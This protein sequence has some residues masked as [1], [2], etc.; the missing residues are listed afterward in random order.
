M[1]AKLKFTKKVF[2]M[3]HDRAIYFDDED[4]R[5]CCILHKGAVTSSVLGKIVADNPGFSFEKV[6]MV[7]I[8][9]KIFSID[10][11][12]LDS[13]VNL[14]RVEVRN[15]EDNSRKEFLRYAL[16]GFEE[17]FE[18]DKS[19]E[20]YKTIW[21]RIAKPFCLSEA[22]NDQID[23]NI[24]D[25]TDG[26]RYGNV[27]SENNKG[28]LKEYLSQI[29][30]FSSCYRPF[31]TDG[32]IH[33]KVLLYQ[34][35]VFLVDSSMDGK[36][37]PIPGKDA[38]IQ[39]PNCKTSNS[40]SLSEIL[41]NFDIDKW[42]KG[43]IEIKNNISI[44]DPLGLYVSD[45]N[46]DA[47]G[48][49]RRIFIWMDKMIDS[50]KNNNQNAISLFHEV[51]CH[52]MAHA[53]MD[54]GLYGLKREF[55]SNDPVYTIF[56]EAYAESIALQVL[57]LSGQT[58]TPFIEDSVTNAGS[59]YASGWELY[60]HNSCNLD[61]WIATKML[62]NNNIAKLIVDSW[63]KYYNKCSFVIAPTCYRCENGKIEVRGENNNWQTLDVAKLKK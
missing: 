26:R 52:E 23:L 47:F 1:R 30:R 11:A 63:K 6:K 7:E 29:S 33:N 57:E 56:E 22:I 35:P 40:T 14:Q 51:F 62:F 41:E 20:P 58:I 5:P 2:D 46:T 19:E 36:N 53:L 50:A 54:V 38:S 34:I 43:N 28:A 39:V 3:H 15:K 21:M 24:H 31:L 27:Y 59:G 17:L 9:P 10:M 4:K 37:I 45:G 55:T 61:Q 44:N 42:L 25:L 12:A 18:E 13:F 48:G 60:K 32:D 16:Y 8:G 49:P